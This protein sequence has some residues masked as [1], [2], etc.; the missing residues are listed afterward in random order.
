MFATKK[1]KYYLVL[2][3]YCHVLLICF[4]ILVNRGHIVL[5]YYLVLI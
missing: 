2:V 3:N 1:K 5:I 4:F